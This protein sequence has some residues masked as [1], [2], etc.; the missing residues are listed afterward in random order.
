MK[1]IKLCRELNMGTKA[2]IDFLKSNN[3]ILENKPSTEI[4]DE[5]VGLIRSNFKCI[6]NKQQMNFVFLCFH[7]QMDDKNF[8]ILSRRI[9]Q[10][11]KRQQ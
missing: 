3:I 10:K 5:Y 9:E 2:I 6:C 7:Q 4:K 1:L 8:D 11:K